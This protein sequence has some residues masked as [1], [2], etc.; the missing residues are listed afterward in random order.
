M[1]LDILL[2]NDDGIDSPGLHAL[3]DALSEIGDVTVVAPAENKSATGRALSRDVAVTE[4]ERGYAVDGTPADCVIVGVEAIGPRPDLVVAGCNAGANIGTYVLGRSGTVSAAVE[5]AFCDVPAIASSML[6]KSEDFQRTVEKDEYAAAAD[7]TR[8][9]AEHAFDSGVFEEADYLNLNAPHPESD[10][11]G[12]RVT[13]PAS[14]YDM[15][16]NH[17]KGRISIDDRMW[18]R[19]DADAITDPE[20]TDRRAVVDG[21]LSVSPLTAPHSTSHHDHLDAL[22]A[23]Y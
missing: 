8:Y 12:M 9:L 3:D 11:R 1:T 23:D 15:T 6:L 13:A 21:F 17:Q 20:G 16:A 2:T 19:I 14:G 5:A 18:D 4:R 22:V 10:V 7:A